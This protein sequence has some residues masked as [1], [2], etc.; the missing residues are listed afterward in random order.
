MPW[1]SEIVKDDAAGA[2]NER[3]PEPSETRTSPLFPS[4]LG[5]VRTISPARLSGPFSVTL[6]EP[7]LVPSEKVTLPETDVVGFVRSASTV[8]VYFLPP[9]A[10]IVA[11][12]P[13]STD[14][15]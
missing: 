4:V 2:E 8:E 7:L 6:F 9:I 14:S 13:E 10:S 12:D 1:L 15:I 3:F 11:A 5:R